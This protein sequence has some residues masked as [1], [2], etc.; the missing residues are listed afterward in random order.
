MTYL[1][2]HLIFVLPALTLLYFGQERPLGGLPRS[3]GARY[4]CLMAGIAFIYTA[5]WDNYVVSENIWSYGSDRVLGTVGFVPIEEYAFFL[6]QPVLTGLW[7]LRLRP[8]FVFSGKTSTFLVRAKSVSILATLLLGVYFLRVESTTYLALIIV[9][10][11]PVILGQWL[12][13]GRLF[14]SRLPLIG[15]AIWPPTLYLW[16]ADSVAI[17][18]NIWHITDATRTMIELPGGLPI[19]EAVFFFLTNTLVVL[20]LEMFLSP[21]NI[22]TLDP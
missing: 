10:A 22:E 11:M 18:S 7:Y 1:Q 13:K 3:V 16:V 14:S 6:L 2:F 21:H 15:A 12:W 9:W 4:L 20:G 19:E 5:P 17:K 8:R